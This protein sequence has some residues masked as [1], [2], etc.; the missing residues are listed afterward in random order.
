MVCGTKTMVQTTD[1]TGFKNLSG[2]GLALKTRIK[3]KENQRNRIHLSACIKA[4]A[5]F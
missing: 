2:L 1:L 4:S 5:F 3:S